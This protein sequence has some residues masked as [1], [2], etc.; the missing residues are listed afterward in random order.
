[1][2]RIYVSNCF[3]L[4]AAEK[5]YSGIEVQM[6]V[7]LLQACCTQ[8]IFCCRNGHANE[9]MGSKYSLNRLALCVLV[10]KLLFLFVDIY[11]QRPKI[12]SGVNFA[13]H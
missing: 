5:L 11:V 7:L 3:Q 12:T 6:E 1:M 10:G 9:Y 8:I 13:F 4:E 2:F